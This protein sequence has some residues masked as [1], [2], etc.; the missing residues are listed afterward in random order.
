MSESRV[1]KSKLNEVESQQLPP[2]PEAQPEITEDQKKTIAIMNSLVANGQDL[3]TVLVL[4]QKNV[5]KEI[6]EKY[7]VLQ[8]WLDTSI[9]ISEQIHNLH[10]LVKNRQ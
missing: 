1:K 3:S 2:M 4:V 7:P 10:K 5:P 6:F 9:D 8:E